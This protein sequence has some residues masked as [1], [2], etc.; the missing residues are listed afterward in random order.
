MLSEKWP[1]IDDLFH[2]TLDADD[3]EALLENEPDPEVA[4]AVR[5]LWRHH[6]AASASGFLE[7]PVTT[8]R[9]LLE[10]AAAEA[11][12]ENDGSGENED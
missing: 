7:H 3:P 2:R 5:R 12:D 9:D 10:R 1:Q 6:L 4:A 8:V 11:S